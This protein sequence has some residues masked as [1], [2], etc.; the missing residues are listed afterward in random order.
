MDKVKYYV[1]QIDR[2]LDCGLQNVIAKWTHPTC[3]AEKLLNASTR[4]IDKNTSGLAKTEGLEEEC[5]EESG[6]YYVTFH[7][8][9]FGDLHDVKHLLLSCLDYNSDLD[10]ESSVTGN[11][12][13]ESD[14]DLQEDGSFEYYK[15]YRTILLPNHVQAAYMCSVH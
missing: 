7:S 4:N 11:E 8:F 5:E 2:L 13:S 15:Q 1:S 14:E 3:P 6:K 9:H 12:S 10:K